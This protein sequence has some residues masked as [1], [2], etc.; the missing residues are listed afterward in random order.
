MAADHASPRRSLGA[1]TYLAQGRAHS[2]YGRD[3][4]ALLQRSLQLLFANYNDAQRDDT[5]LFHVDDADFPPSARRAVLDAHA[6]RPLRFETVPAK[7]WALPAKLRPGASAASNMSGW[8][9]WPRFS[10][11]YRHMV[12]WYVLGLW[13][14]LDG[15]GYKYVM[16]MDEDSFILSPLSPSGIV[17]ANVF[18]W[19]R[20]HD[21]GFGYRMVSYESGFDRERFHTFV[22]EYLTRHETNATR[23]SRWLLDSC[24]GGGA[25]TSSPSSSSSSNSGSSSDG[26]AS[27]A[28]SD[29]DLSS[30]SVRECGHL[31]TPPPPP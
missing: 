15:W 13:E 23:R 16:R 2:S 22:R 9:G 17:G 6:G 1:I 12:R 29:R 27:D 25:A 28:S 14:V 18:E 3:S 21:V 4:L 5:I 8:A 20:D 11:G 10:V 24:R 19:M 7:H 30:F 31:C 26:G